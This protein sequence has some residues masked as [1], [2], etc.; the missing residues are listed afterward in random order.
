MKT[1][2]E[3]KTDIQQDLDRLK[4]EGK[5]HHYLFNIEMYP[6]IAIQIRDYFKKLGYIVEYRKCKS[7]GGL[8][9]DFIF[10]L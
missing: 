7:C 4:K 2:E 1:I 10:D 8:R 3:W 6:E 5:K 9:H